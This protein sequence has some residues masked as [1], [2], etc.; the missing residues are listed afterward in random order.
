MGDSELA[1]GQEHEGRMRYALFL[2]GGSGTRLWPMSLRREPK[3]LIPLPGGKDLLQLAVHRLS[4]VVDINRRYICA[5]E[6]HKARIL[7][8]PG[9]FHPRCYIGEP[10]GRDTLAAVATGMAVIS[11][12]DPQAIVGVFTSDHV[13]EPVTQFRSIVMSGYQFVEENPDT[14]LTFGVAPRR[15]ATEFGYLEL[16]AYCGAI[17]RRV[18]RFRE[19]P[20][21]STAQ[22]YLEAGP[23]R[24]LWNSGM[25]IWKASTFLACVKR[26]EPD[27]FSGVTE[28]A[29]AWQGPDRCA[30]LTST[31]PRLRRISVDYAI[32]EPASADPAIKIAAIPMPLEWKD[33]GSWLSF[34]DVCDKDAMGNAH[35]QGKHLLMGCRDSLIVSS[36]GDHLVAGIGCEGLIIVHTKEAT[37]VCPKDRAGDIR[38]L[39]ERISKEFGDRYT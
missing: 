12:E 33:V 28:I 15:P 29:Q 23:N 20:D 24:Y 7:Q 5:L 2:A 25:F 37:L 3:Q 38:D 32:M 6:E 13:I 26:F 8:V 21:I 11:L 16:G 30:K 9:L 34:A 19:K 1:A 18:A 17:A 27:V 36:D 14:L 31:Y 10:M 22:Q 39:Q 4:A 35:T